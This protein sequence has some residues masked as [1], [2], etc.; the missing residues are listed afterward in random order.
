MVVVE[1]EELKKNL[2]KVN[3]Y[4]SYYTWICCL[5]CFWSTILFPTIYADRRWIRWRLAGSTRISTRTAWNRW[6]ATTILRWSCYINWIVPFV[7]FLI[8]FQ[9]TLN[10]L[11]LNWWE[12]RIVPLVNLLSKSIFNWLTC[13]IGHSGRIRILFWRL[14]NQIFW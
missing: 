10:F 11:Y 9:L 5:F 12:W 7:V 4:D 3:I 6:W 2:E 8:D 14:E 13:K 1:C